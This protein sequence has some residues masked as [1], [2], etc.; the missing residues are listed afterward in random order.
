MLFQILLFILIQLSKS[1]EIYTIYKEH[2]I[3]LNEL[4]TSSLSQYSEIIELL[5]GTT[6][7]PNIVKDHNQCNK[8]YESE[9]ITAREHLMKYL[10]YRLLRD[11][12]DEEREKI[13]GDESFAHYD[14]AIHLEIARRLGDPIANLIRANQELRD[15]GNVK[16]V[17]RYYMKGLEKEM[18]YDTEFH[19]DLNGALLKDKFLHYLNINKQS[20]FHEYLE[21]YQKGFTPY[22][23]K[24][25]ISTVL[26]MTGKLMYR[27]GSTD[28]EMYDIFMRAYDLGDN[29]GLA[30]AGILTEYGIGVEKNKTKAAEMYNKGKKINTLSEVRLGLLFNQHDSPIGYSQDEAIDYLES[31]RKKGHIDACY[32]LRK[33]YLNESFYKHNAVKADQYLNCLQQMPNHDHR[34]IEQGRVFLMTQ[35]DQVKDKNMTRFAIETIYHLQRLTFDNVVNFQILYELAER[36]YNQEQY[37]TALMIFQFLHELGFVHAGFMAATMF[38]SGK[39]CSNISETIR[40]QKAY[41]IYTQIIKMKSTSLYAEEHVKFNDFIGGL[42]E[43]QIGIMYLRGKLGVKDFEQAV[44]WL[45][46]SGKLNKLPSSVMLGLLRQYVDKEGKY[47][48]EDVNYYFNRTVLHLNHF[49]IIHKMLYANY[50]IDQ[51]FE[52]NKNLIF[53]WV[54]IVMIVFIIKNVINGICFVIN[55]M[56][57][58]EENEEV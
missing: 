29:N 24:T 37:H 43:Y 6:T 42:A 5:F 25:Y 40:Y 51:F 49:T 28:K 10:N 57:K 34:A 23:P 41:D 44:K 33:I 12:T 39:G 32:H 55:K 3:P 48:K 4:I 9:A 56:K 17:V 7:I 36:Y 22:D 58:K 2:E 13:I 1:R 53:Y 16:D 31:A 38:E 18:K 15:G 45:E 30:L 54:K 52:Q 50:E 21:L 19:L 35:N 46:E 14:A 26:V 27:L 11:I 20:K 47:I 8:T